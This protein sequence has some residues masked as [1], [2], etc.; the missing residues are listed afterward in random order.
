LGAKAVYSIDVDDK[1]VIRPDA[2]PDSLQRAKKAGKRVVA[3]VASACATGTGL[4]DPLEEISAFCRE[5]A[6]WMHV[7]GAHGV[8]ALL[9]AKERKHLRGIEHAD[10][11]TWDAHKMLRTSSLCTAVLFRDAGAFERAFQQEASYL[12]YG[13]GGKGIDLIHRTV[14]CTKAPLGLKVFLNLAWRGEQGM[15]RY[16]EE[17]Y[18]LTHR[19]YQ[20]IRNRSGFEC[21][22]VP[23]SNILCFRYGTESTDSLQVSIR[24]RLLEEGRFHIS[25]AEVN[26]KRYLRL[27][28]MS[29]QTTEETI[30]EMLDAIERVA[31]NNR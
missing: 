29:P 17:Q 15:A 23:E 28:V 31:A 27:V 6:L 1:D 24:E 9:S 5:E 12:F 2:L 21:P 14:E 16:V 13:E 11:L 18:E 7:D 3:L 19:L 10:S 26:S 8:S 30:E 22:F 25:S 4:H 20:C